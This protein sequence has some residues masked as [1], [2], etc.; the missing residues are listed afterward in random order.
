ML[1]YINLKNSENVQS[2]DFIMASEWLYFDGKKT[3]RY[4]YDS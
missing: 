3:H 1:P 2:V 4:I